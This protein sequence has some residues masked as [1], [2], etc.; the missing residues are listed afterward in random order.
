MSDRDLE[1][2]EVVQLEAEGVPPPVIEMRRRAWRLVR[3]SPNWRATIIAVWLVSL[4]ALVLPVFVLPVIEARLLTRFVALVVALL[5]LY[6]V[7]GLG[8][9][10]SLCHGVFVGV[11]SYAMT[12]MVGRAGLPHLFGLLAAPPAGF[13][14]GCFVGLLALRIRATYLGPVTLGVAVIFPMIVK[15]FGWFTGGASG[16][17]SPRQLAAPDIFG[18]TQQRAYRWNHL[19]VVAVGV[20]A[21]VLLR[22]L[23]AS[24]VGLA[25]RATAINATSAASSGVNVR[26]VGVLTFGVGAAFGALGG[27]LLVL[28]TPIVGA[29]SYDLFRSLGYYAVVVVGGVTAMTGVALG[30]GLLVGVPWL[31]DLYALRVGP[32]LV[33]GVLL[34]AAITIAPGGLTVPVR[35]FFDNVVVIEEPIPDQPAETAMDPDMPPGVPGA[36]ARGHQSVSGW[37]P[38]QANQYD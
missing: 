33:F 1:P 9:Q 21:V 18:F 37:A 13:V 30:A 10:L 7:V 16:L 24:P 11:G 22:N 26:R 35:R 25:I 14:V 12:L 28:E 2:V 31:L 8:A 38:N 19:V 6:L 29:D 15:R 4:V 17:P 5:G 23:V 36:P 3:G 20:L 27:A 32:N 34:L